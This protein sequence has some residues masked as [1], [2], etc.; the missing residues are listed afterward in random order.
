MIAK[1]VN[2]HGCK[3]VAIS[4]SN[5]SRFCS[6]A[7]FVITLIIIT[8][9]FFPYQQGKQISVMI[10]TFRQFHWHFCNDQESH[11]KSDDTKTLRQSLAVAATLHICSILRKTPTKMEKKLVRS[12][13]SSGGPGNHRKVF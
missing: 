8:N 9:R 11:H 7:N 10:I 12:A 2:N 5:R 13:I 3:C 1:T 6:L 4:E